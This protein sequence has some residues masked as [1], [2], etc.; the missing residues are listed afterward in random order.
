MS[1]LKTF[2]T[3]NYSILAF[4]TARLIKEEGGICSISLTC[5]ENITVRTDQ[6]YIFN[7]DAYASVSQQMFTKNYQC[8]PAI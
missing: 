2:G 6:S 3:M 7:F 1:F 5:L 4:M 8:A